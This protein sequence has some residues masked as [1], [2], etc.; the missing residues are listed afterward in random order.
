MKLTLVL[1]GAMLG[2]ALCGAA[3]AQYTTGNELQEK[4]KATVAG[5]TSEQS[6]TWLSGFCIGFIQ[7][8][9]DSEA[10]WEAFEHVEKKYEPF[11][12]C[13]PKKG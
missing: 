6:G 8:V 2:L 3:N 11:H 13:W 10:M 5:A 12:Y 7:A 1:A 4:C 9:E